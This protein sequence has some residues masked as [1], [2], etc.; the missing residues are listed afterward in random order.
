MRKLQANQPTVIG[1]DLYRNLPVEPGQRELVTQLQQPNIIGIQSLDVLTGTAA[2]PSIPEERIG[3]NDIPVDPDEVV[4]RNLL[5]AGNDQGTLFSFSLRLA[6]A[7]L[8]E[9]E[10]YPQDSER[11][12]GHLQLGQ[13]VFLPLKQNS[14]GYQ[15]IDANGYQILLN[16]RSAD[17]VARQVTL[18]EAAKVKGM[19][20][21]ELADRTT[22]NAMACFG[23]KHFS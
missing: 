3:F 21:Q 19:S 7:Y 12:P 1:L 20:H 16:Y 10:I 18:E 14:G 17:N 6:L 4:R 13:A 5:F 2:P 15:T 11:H 23:L 9:Q 22:K 8:E